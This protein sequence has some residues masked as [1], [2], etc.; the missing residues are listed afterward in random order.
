MSKNE[1]YWVF[2]GIFCALLGPSSRPSM[3]LF[4]LLL[5]LG[6]F[7]AAG[8]ELFRDSPPW[9]WWHRPEKGS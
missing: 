7:I 4:E 1:R 9:K 6:F 2:L 5:A 8:V 3:Q